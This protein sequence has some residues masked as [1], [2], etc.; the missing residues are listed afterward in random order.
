MKLLQGW[1][2]NMA[3][4]LLKILSFFIFPVFV[5]I[6]H[7]VFCFYGI[8]NAFL[9]MDIPM[10][11]LGGLAISYMVVLFL[12]FFREKDFISIKKGFVFILVVVSVVVLIA[13][14][15]EFYEFLLKYFFHVNTQPSLEDTLED[16]FMGL[17]G[18]IVGA[19]G[20]RK[21]FN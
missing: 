8:Y 15:W 18:G 4:K 1:K 13:V 14:L 20:F 11:F 19:I 21:I 10:H 6:I 5:F 17:V 2:N 9:W 16:L 12:K 7:L 3:S